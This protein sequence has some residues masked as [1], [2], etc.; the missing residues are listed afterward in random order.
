MKDAKTKLQTAYYSLLNGNVTID[1][2]A[3]GIG[4]KLNPPD[5]YPQVIISDW[6]D[7]EESDKYHLG[8][9]VTIRLLIYDRQEQDNG[10]RADLYS[11]SDQIKQIIKA[12]P[13]PI[14]LSPNF[15]NVW[16]RLDNEV[17]LPKDLSDT[18]ITF[19]I[20]QR[21]RHEIEQL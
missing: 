12:R 10:S 14:D 7:T 5:T 11:I 13:D 15:K 19:G 20:Q 2:S 4:D 18:H 3:V 17:S 16:T 21:F 6:T 9:E 8:S 1:G